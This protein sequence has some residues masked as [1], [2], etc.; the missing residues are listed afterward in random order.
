MMLQQQSLAPAAAQRDAHNETCP[1]TKGI[2]KK[3]LLALLVSAAAVAT[4]FVGANAQPSIGFRLL[5]LDGRG[6]AWTGDV[7]PASVT[8]AFAKGPTQTPNAMNCGLIGPVDGLLAKSRIAENAFR[9]EVR[10]AFDMWEAVANITFDEVDDPAR[11]G[12]VIGAQLHPVG[13]AFANVAYKHS[14]DARDVR[15]IDRSLVCLNPEQPWK[16]GFDGNLAAYDIRYTVA[17]EIGHA[18]G[19]DHPHTTGQLMHFRYEE[20]FRNLQPGDIEGAVKLY[21]PRSV[22]ATPAP[23]SVQDPIMAKIE[24]AAINDE[25]AA[26]TE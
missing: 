17:H 9:K 23:S 11:A 18:I 15:S 10:A 5:K 7:R 20:R 13:R 24:A 19:L 1:H 25:Q 3:A 14:A 21:G 12:I 8:Y 2:A 26:P 16:I 6:V 22:I 4:V